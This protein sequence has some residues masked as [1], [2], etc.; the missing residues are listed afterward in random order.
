VII[1]LGICFGVLLVLLGYLLAHWRRQ[2]AWRQ[3][4]I[5]RQVVRAETTALQQI[6]RINEM[7][8]RARDQLRRGGE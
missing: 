6:M 1:S 5:L 7:Y 4:R 8:F 3:L 2:A